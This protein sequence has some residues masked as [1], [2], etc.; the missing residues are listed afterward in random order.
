MKVALEYTKYT[1]YTKYSKIAKYTKYTKYTKIAKYTKI[2]KYE[3][4]NLYILQNKILKCLKS[5]DIVRFFQNSRNKKGFS[6]VYIC[7]HIYKYNRFI[8][9]Y[10]APQIWGGYVCQHFAREVRLPAFV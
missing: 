9:I 3:L 8:F 4:W 10:I 6:N 7:V 2:T 1:K 5:F